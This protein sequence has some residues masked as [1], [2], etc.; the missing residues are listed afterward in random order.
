MC[1]LIFLKW[2]TFKDLLT[3]NH[4]ELCSAL[5]GSLTEGGL[6]ENG[7]MYMYEG[8]PSLFT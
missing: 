3:V 5:T 1:R 2:I 8:V 6:G 4:M 7:Y